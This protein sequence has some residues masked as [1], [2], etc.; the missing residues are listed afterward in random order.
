MLAHLLLAG[1]SASSVKMY[2]G[3]GLVEA[4]EKATAGDTKFYEARYRT[5][6]ALE[7]VLFY[8][9][10]TEEERQLASRALDACVACEYGEP[11]VCQLLSPSQEKAAAPT[12][13]SMF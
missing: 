5:L 1:D 4:R 9:G 8:P 11:K 12:N 6:A 3:K 7:Q 2:V 13:A 10:S